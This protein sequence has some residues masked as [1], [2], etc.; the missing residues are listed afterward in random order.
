MARRG[1]KIFRNGSA[2]QGHASPACHNTVMIET[3]TITG[4]TRKPLG[5]K[6]NLF[7]GERL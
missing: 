4:R 7:G 3:V 6:L 1:R 5:R 2:R